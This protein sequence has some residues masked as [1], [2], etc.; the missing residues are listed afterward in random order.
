MRTLK[1]LFVTAFVIC[2]VLFSGCSEKG[3]KGNLASDYI[4]NLTVD[5]EEGGEVWLDPPG[6]KYR[7]NTEVTLT[8]VAE[9]GY[10]FGEWT[11]PNGDEVVAKNNRW[12]IEMDGH[13]QLVASFTEL[14][15]NQVAAPTALPLGGRVPADTEITLTTTTNG[16][17]IYYTVDGT[18]PTIENGV[19]YSNDNKPVVPGGGMTLKAFALKDG[20]SDSNIATFFYTTITV[21]A[22]THNVGGIDFSMR[23]A[24]GGVTFPFGMFTDTVTIDHAFWISETEVTCEL[25]HAVYTWVTA[26][27][28]GDDR[29]H[30]QNTGKA[31]S[32]YGG[33]TEPVTGISWYDAIVWCNA[34]T[35]YFNAENN[36]QWDCV[37][38]YEGNIVRDSR[39]ENAD[40]C[41]NVNASPHAKGFRLP[42]S[43]E[44]EM[45]ARFIN[46]TD[47]LPWNHACGDLFGPCY[48]PNE[49]ETISTKVGDY[50]WYAENSGY[51]T[52]PVAEK[53][54]NAFGLFDMSGNVSELCFDLHSKDPENKKRVLRGG[55]Y[56]SETGT[57]YL[58]V[59]YENWTDTFN[60]YFSQ[61]FR[62]ARTD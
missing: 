62:L 34:L 27:E 31:G 6:G 52:H 58:L 59:S 60:G 20:M 51:T 11:G 28:R 49:G 23:L 54:R 3:G 36:L 61:G 18:D 8:P 10:E 30:F 1:C 44:W 43:K 2:T 57:Y 45:A 55:Y 25:W 7:K 35:E 19:V 50:A 29:Y 4:L 46:G 32:H 14:E 47:W 15:P 9:A 48:A 39:G 56:G 26:E 5:P 22:V 41:D 40:A 24:P 42:V 38:T 13:K 21:E 16:A 17:T 37:Y 12:T 33:A 53:G